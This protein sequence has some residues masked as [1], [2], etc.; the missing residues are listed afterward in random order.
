MAQPLRLEVFETLEIPEGPAMMMP[1]QIEDIRLSAYERGYLAGWEDG[2]A[3]VDADANARRTSIERQV[4]SLSFTYHEARGHVLKALRPVL[5]AMIVCVLPVAA[6]ASVVPV[7]IETLLPLAQASAEAPVLLRLPRG[8]RPGFTAAI[9]GLVMP[10]LDIQETDDLADGQAEF[11][12]GAAETRV[13]LTHA[14]DLVGRAIDTFYEIH[15]EESR[16]A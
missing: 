3:Q 10:P 8:A 2:S 14:A 13:D 1:E 7:L 4:E 6:R 5:E 16:H 12:F 15:T 11:V 9:E